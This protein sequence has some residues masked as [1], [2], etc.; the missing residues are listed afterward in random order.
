MAIH[1]QGMYDVVVCGGGVAGTMAAIS[2]ARNGARTILVEKGPFLGGVLSMGYF[3]H[4]F[5]ANSGK[6]AIGGLAEELIERLK[7][8]NGTLGHLRYQGGHLYTVTPVDSEMVKCTLMRMAEEAGVEML[9]ETIINNVVTAGATITAVVLQSKQGTQTLQAK[10]VI[11]AT[12]DGDVAYMA[13]AAYEKG[14]EDGKVQPV[15][16]SMRVSNVDTLRMMK[17]IPTDQAVLMAKR[18]GS[19]TEKPVYFV[20]RLGK[21]DDTPEAKELFTDK[22]RQMFCLCMLEDD[23]FLNI[24]RVVGVDATNLRENSG[25]LVQARLQVEE[26]YHFVRKYLPG[27]ENCHLIAGSFLGVRETRRICGEY[28]LTEEDIAAGRMFDDNICLVGYPMDMHDPDGGNVVFTGI[29]GDGT[30][31]IPYRCMLPKGYQNLLVAGRCISVTHKALASARTMS[32]CMCMGQAAGVAASIA[33]AENK[34]VGSI[35]VQG[36][37]DKLIQQKAILR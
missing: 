19:E 5:Y 13:G 18:P 17:E 31:G 2:A 34:P 32:A 36:L 14:R 30:Y 1:S 23:I 20:G 4:S 37:Q 24:S 35:S 26:M 7:K 22:N 16:L 12:G 25:A 6:K 3:P 21:W 8:V 15:S 27:F 9:F 29:G 28:Q 33:G 11:D 10:T